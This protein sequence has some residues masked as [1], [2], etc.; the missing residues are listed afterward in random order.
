M[1][2]S[3]LQY[4]KPQLTRQVSATS[5]TTPKDINPDNTIM[6]FLKSMD[7]K[8]AAVLNRSIRQ[9]EKF[10]VR[11][12]QTSTNQTQ[13]SRIQLSTVERQIF[14][15]LELRIQK[16]PQ[17]E[18]EYV[19]QLLGQIEN[20][21][22]KHEELIQYFKNNK[23][24]RM[25]LRI[26]SNYGNNT[27]VGL[28]GIELLNQQQKLIKIT[29][30][31]SDDDSNNTI[32][33]LINGHNLIINQEYMWITTYK[34]FPII[35][36]L[37]YIEDSD[38]LTYVKI[39]NF[40]KNRKELDKCV[41]NIEILQNEQI[42]WS[43]QLKR[44]VGNTF[45]EYAD[46]LELK[47]NNQIKE[48]PQPFYQSMQSMVSKKSDDNIINQSKASNQFKHQKPKVMKNPFDDEKRIKQPEPQTV[49]QQVNQK[50]LFKN[51][52]NLF[53]QKQL[54]EEDSTI[55]YVK[56]G[57]AHIAAGQTKQRIKGITIPDCPIGNLLIFKLLQNWGDMFYIGL[58]GIEIFD[59]LGNKV[60]VMEASGFFKNPYVLF[61]DNY[62]TQDEK[63][64][65][66][67][68][69]EKNMEIKL[70][71][72]ET[73]IAMIRI[74]N[75][76]KGRT[77]RNKGVRR[78]E[79][80]IGMDLSDQVDPIFYDEIKQANATCNS[81]NAE[82]IMFTNNEQILDK[83]SQSDWLNRLHENQIQQQKQI[84]ENTIKFS[85]PD[86]A[87]FNKHNQ[88]K[89]NNGILIKQPSD[90]LLQ[91]NSKKAFA[92]ILN[93]LPTVTVKTLTIYILKNWGD[94]YVGLDK[95]EI[96][97]KYGQS[98]KIKK[99]KVITYQSET[100]MN[101][102]ERWQFHNGQIRIQFSFP[103]CIQISR[104]LI[105]NYNKEDELEKGVQL[106]NIE[107]DDQ[108]LNTIQGIFLRKGHGLIDANEPQI[109]DLPYQQNIKT[110]L[111]N[112][113]F[114]KSI[115]LDYETAQL[116]QGTKIT[117]KLISTWGDLHYIGLNGIE[118]FDPNGDLIM[119]KLYSKP[120]S[121]KELPDMEMDVRT[122]D[123]LLNNCNV[124]LD[125]KQ[126]WLAPF[127]N[128]YT[129]RLQTNINSSVF[130]QVN[131]QVNK[132]ILLF[133][134]PQQV[135][136]ISFYNYSKTPVRGVKE[137]EISM[138]DYIIYQGYLNLSTLTQTPKGIIG[139]NKTTVLFTRDERLIEQIGTVQI[140]DSII[141]SE[142]TLINENQRET[143]NSIKNKQVRNQQQKL[144]KELDRPTTTQVY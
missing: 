56:R 81:D 139:N 95:I 107:G 141:G 122:P 118:L 84:L 62:L 111:A 30:I 77:H 125:A 92:S 28:T 23:T 27:Q 89:Q 24:K 4:Q 117:I 17:K 135:S 50:R 2:V 116:P 104:I 16:L 120:Y 35:I 21:E 128:S 43:G 115:Y 96:H 129:N 63:C 74:W 36:T 119:P 31:I 73:K 19:K 52:M 112:Y 45:T 10:N 40:N 114:E 22:Q 54:T 93:T 42:I 20:G 25:Q 34:Q 46:L 32:T 132:L 48:I 14:N 133:D 124:T 49:K 5:R 86:T 127:V 126:I 29:S 99:Y 103:Q 82:Y 9:G 138:D 143:I 51:P 130:D 100:I 98:L 69:I 53:P 105:W 137:C 110:I 59:Y 11:N 3:R 33:N 1:S 109:I 6:S 101:N 7:T 71:F 18:Q 142:T 76:N 108:I 136:A 102:D 15:N 60:Q 26:L 55:L 67:E 131:Y 57:V 121:V 8:Q 113:Q 68:R 65:C 44:G 80:L 39:W 94:K 64:M 41:Q 75:Y 97:D 134:S 66:L 58:T 38:I 90:K 88:Q 79:I 37:F 47:I 70:K 140:R 123:K 144:Y 12:Q 13:N 106:I 61:D 83:I 85:R 87:T 91:Q 78:M 72:K